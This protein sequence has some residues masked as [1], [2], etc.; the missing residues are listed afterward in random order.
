MGWPTMSPM[1]KMSSTLVRHL[2]IDVDEATVC[3]GHTGRVGCNFL[4]VAG[5]KYSG[6]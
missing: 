3:D 4:A 1:A 2:D 6:K 5:A